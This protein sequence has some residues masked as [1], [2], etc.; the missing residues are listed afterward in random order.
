M[1]HGCNEVARDKRGATRTTPPPQPS[2]FLTEAQPTNSTPGGR[3][4]PGGGGVLQRRQ[5]L[6]DKWDSEREGGQ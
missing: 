4:L 2:A 3:H 6:C 5:H 1:A